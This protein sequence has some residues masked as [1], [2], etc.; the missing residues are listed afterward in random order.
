MNPPD[1]VADTVQLLIPSLVGQSIVTGLSKWIA[2][3][4]L[5]VGIDPKSFN[6]PPL[7]PISH[8]ELQ[9]SEFCKFTPD[10]GTLQFRLDIKKLRAGA[11]FAGTSLS[12]A[13]PR[14]EMGGR[15][16]WTIPEIVRQ[17]TR[18]FFDLLCDGVIVANGLTAS[19]QAARLRRDDFSPRRAG[20]GVTAAGDYFENETLLV[21]NIGTG[22]A[23]Y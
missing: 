4:L 9:A 23:E 21:S 12:E 1:N 18:E 17:R 13:L 6:L 16:A 10:D 7:I 19:N 20:A 8:A 3:D 14:E 22:V 11:G 2:A 5:F 15:N